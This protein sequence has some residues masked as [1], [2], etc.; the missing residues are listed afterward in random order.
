MGLSLV[1]LLLKDWLCLGGNSFGITMLLRPICRFDLWFNL[2][3]WKAFSFL[4]LDS[5]LGC[6]GWLGSLFLRSWFDGLRLLLSFLG[7]FNLLVGLLDIA[8]CLSCLFLLSCLRG[9][10]YGNF[11]L[12]C[13]SGGI[14]RWRRRIRYWLNGRFGS[15][16]VFARF[17]SCLRRFDG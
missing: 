2:I 9:Q 13:L 14:Y 12:L 10:L 16:F 4:L 5:T 7:V 3:F 15:V 8:F 6:F 1:H 17:R 11:I